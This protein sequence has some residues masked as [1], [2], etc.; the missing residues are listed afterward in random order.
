MV[1]VG[2]GAFSGLIFFGKYGSQMR[3]IKVAGEP[4]WKPILRV[5][6]TLLI[7][8]VVLLPYLLLGPE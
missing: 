7:A 4:F 2:F 1:G 6:L 5:L 3:D 8:G